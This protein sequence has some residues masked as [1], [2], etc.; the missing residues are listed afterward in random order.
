MMAELKVDCWV[1]NLVA[2]RVVLLGVQKAEK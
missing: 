1:V 2:Q